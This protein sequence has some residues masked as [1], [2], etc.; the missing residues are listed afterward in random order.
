MPRRVFIG[1][2]RQE[3]YPFELQCSKSE[4]EREGGRGRSSMVTGKGKE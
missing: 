4:T 1:G 3:I 2:E